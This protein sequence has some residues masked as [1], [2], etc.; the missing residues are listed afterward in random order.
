MDVIVDSSLWIEGLRGQTIAEIEAAIAD[1]TIVLPPLVVAELLSGDL[2]PQDREFIGDLLQE[3]SLHETP[4]RHWMLVGEL[5]RFLAARGVNVTIPDAHVAQCAIDRDAK[6]LSRD[7]IF[8][9]IAKHTS[10]RLA[11]LR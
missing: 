5:R 4:L 11:H 7:D 9:L 6:L 10:L 1:G 2:T 8:V 3:F